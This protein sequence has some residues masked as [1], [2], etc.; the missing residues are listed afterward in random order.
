VL[1]LSPAHA[2]SVDAARQTA[3][4]LGFPCMSS[5]ATTPSPKR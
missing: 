1:D 2:A 5:A 4:F 3:D